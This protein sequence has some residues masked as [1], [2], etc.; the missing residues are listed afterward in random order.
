M[1]HFSGFDHL[2]RVCLGRDRGVS[3]YGPEKFITHLEHKLAAYTW[4][5]V[6]NYETE[7]VI[8]AHG[9]EEAGA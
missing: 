9:T 1:D 3:L 4:D 8:V 6:E 7:F 2:L 5:L